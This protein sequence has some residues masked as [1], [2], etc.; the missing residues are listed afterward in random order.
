MFAD[1]FHGNDDS[2]KSV[3]DGKTGLEL[4]LKN[5]YD[6]ILLDIRMPQYSGMDFLQD[7]KKQR[8]SELKKIVVTSLLQ[9]DETQI[10][11]LMGFGIHA[12]EEKPSNFQQIEKLQKTIS[13]IRE[14][15]NSKSM[16]IMI[17][18]NQP[19]NTA[20]LSKY[21]Q[22]K[23]FQTTVTNDPW[24]GFK[25][26]QDEQFDVILLEMDRQESGGL[27]LIKMLATN[28]ILQDQNIFILPARFGHNNKI[29]DLLKREGI[30]GIL[31]NPI[32]PEEILKM[33]T[34]GLSFQKRITLGSN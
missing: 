7:L 24:E 31:Q 6:L 25:N 30:N 8:P 33:I 16:K 29:K 19:D 10:K 17:I 32:D 27:K 1:M 3:N 26:I 14:G 34:E 12:V 11:E 18:D 21:F 23:G 15:K 2:I 22:S 4:V 20:M 9:F 28:E 5:D 13:Q